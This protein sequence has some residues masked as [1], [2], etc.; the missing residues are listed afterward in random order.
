MSHIM[1]I[2]VSS[3]DTLK[4]TKKSKRVRV[5]N[6]SILSSN[7]VT[8]L[9]VKIM[10]PIGFYQCIPAK[11]VVIL[12]HGMM[13]SIEDYEDFASYLSLHNI[14]VVLPEILGHG[15]ALV[16]GKRGYMGEDGKGYI[17]AIKDMQ[18]VYKFVRKM[19]KLPIVMLGFSLGSF[20]VR[21][22]TILG[23]FDYYFSGAILVGTGN[24]SKLELSIA[25]I[26]AK[27]KINK[28]GADNTTGVVDDLTVYSYNKK[29]KKESSDFAWL[30]R[31]SKCQEEFSPEEY[32]V[33]PQLFYDLI[34]SMELT[35]K[36]EGIF[37]NNPLLLISGSEDPVTGNL[38]KLV[39]FFNL[40]GCDEVVAYSVK[41]YRHAVL[42]DT[43]AK[44]VSDRIIVWLDSVF[45]EGAR[46]VRQYEGQ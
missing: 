15:N 17:F 27:S 25:K 30:F 23:M 6:C 28:F 29:F 14:I 36:D 3:E 20:L 40:W 43:S 44:S 33:S 46:F 19:F 31:D 4:G 22:G 5:Q 1:D 35:S 13:E 7:K 16:D 10:L 38:S 26:L 37:T 45:E 24:K 18:K 42:R 21:E 12:M 11:G 41:G 8:E 39:R 32:H 2:V 9:P 34:R